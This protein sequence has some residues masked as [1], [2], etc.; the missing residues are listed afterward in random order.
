MK[1][2][3]RT[4]MLS[5][6]HSIPEMMSFFKT[7]GY[8]G[9]EFCL[10]DYFFHLRPDLIDPNAIAYHLKTANNLGLSISAVSNH[11]DY[12]SNEYTFEWIKRAIPLSKLYG[13]DIFII[14][15]TS[16]A[17]GKARGNRDYDRAVACI[18]EFVK[19]G[20]D[21]NVRIALEPEPPHVFTS[22]QEFLQLCELIDSD[23]LVMNF[24]I[25]HAFLTDTDVLQSIEKVKDKLV[26]VHVED[27]KKGQ[28]VHLLP[29]EGSLDLASVIRKLHDI[30]YEGALAFDAYNYDY[31]VAAP[32][33]YAR[34]RAILKQVELEDREI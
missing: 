28:H 32:I 4:Q 15:A 29:G 19:I 5:H 8:D 34:L 21:C 31:E 20:E 30:G 7:I 1:L 12:I 10:E 6:T 3:A 18:R 13:T 25:G 16:T 23:N 9:V 33:A 2:V 24:D 14:S 27:M 22:T 11:M 17:E 26:H